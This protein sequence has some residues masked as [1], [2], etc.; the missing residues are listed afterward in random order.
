MADYSRAWI[1]AAR[2]SQVGGYGRRG[3]G[4]GGGHDDLE[5]ETENGK[6]DAR[7]PHPGVVYSHTRGRGR[8]DT[9]RG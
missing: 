9:A 5:S 4:E 6:S 3:E 7:G 1:A 8:P 2:W